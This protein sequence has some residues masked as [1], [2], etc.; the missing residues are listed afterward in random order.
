MIDVR[1]QPE[2]IDLAGALA[3]AEASGAG[4]VAS[5]TGIVRDDGGVTELFLEHYPGVTERALGDLAAEAA[6]RWPLSAVTVIHRVGAMV[7]GDR[8]VLVVAASAHRQ[9]AIEATAFLIDR[10]KTE[11]PFWKRERRGE[12]ASWVEPRASD[13][14]AA[15]R[16]RSSHT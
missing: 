16:W 7:P 1:I 4:A 6:G 13:D 5:F 10:L 3:R 8:I 11:A 15:E 2:P 14:A 12:T 9:A